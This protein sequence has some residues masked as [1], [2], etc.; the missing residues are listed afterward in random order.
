MKIDILS[1]QVV[2]K[3]DVKADDGNWNTLVCLAPQLLVEVEWLLYIDNDS[4]VNGASQ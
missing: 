4:A 1:I 3:E 2:P